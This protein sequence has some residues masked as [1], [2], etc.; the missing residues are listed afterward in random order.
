M[1]GL[2][3]SVAVKAGQDVK[4]GEELCVVEA[5]KMEN[6]LRAERD[7][8]V[9][10]LHAAPGDAQHEQRIGQGGRAASDAEFGLHRGQRDDHAPH[11]GAAH[12]DHRQGDA[13]TDPGRPAIRLRR[14]RRER[15][16]LH[17]LPPALRLCRTPSRAL[18]RKRPR[19]GRVRLAPGAR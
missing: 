1:P 9:A 17:V 2:L 19:R 15:P 6:I 5:M 3:K 4:A 12:R 10:K 8:T 11:P 13:E 18:P 14:G 16:C 7:G